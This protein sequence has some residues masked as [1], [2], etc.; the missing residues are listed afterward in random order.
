MCLYARNYNTISLS[1]LLSPTSPVPPL[2]DHLPPHPPPHPPPPYSLG[3]PL[4]HH[5]VLIKHA[6]RPKIRFPS[7]S[8]EYVANV[9]C[10]VDSLLEQRPPSPQDAL[11]NLDPCEVDILNCRIKPTLVG[12]EEA[13]SIGFAGV[14]AV[15]V[16]RGTHD[17]D[18]A[19]IGDVVDS[20]AEQSLER[21]I[22]FL[23][24]GAVNSGAVGEEL[25]G[26]P[27]SLGE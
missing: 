4:N 2:K 1:A 19:E 20:T 9:V 14:R 22:V 7:Q 3:T 26:I 8:S 23:R 16:G 13:E 11:H 15:K 24:C 17:N 21:S 10:R 25:G 5:R 6:S 12:V 27:E 18:T